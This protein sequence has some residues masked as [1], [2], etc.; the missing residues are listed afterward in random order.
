MGTRYLGTGWA[1][2][3]DQLSGQLRHVVGA[4]GSSCWTDRQTDRQLDAEGVMCVKEIRVGKNISR[5][6]SFQG[7]RDGST[8]K[9]KFGFDIEPSQSGI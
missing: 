6:L 7:W 5:L 1:G 8:V 9:G 2:S 4:F 3:S